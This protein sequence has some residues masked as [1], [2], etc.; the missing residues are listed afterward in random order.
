M[1]RKG[2]GE[3]VQKGLLREKRSWWLLARENAAVRPKIASRGSEPPSQRAFWK[4]RWGS[5]A[6][7][8]T[9]HHGFTYWADYGTCYINKPSLSHLEATNF[10]APMRP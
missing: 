7:G 1:R 2:K 5:M 10:D 6:S 8:P 9:S 4:A 3:V